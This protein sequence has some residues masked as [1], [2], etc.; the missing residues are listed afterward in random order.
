MYN[1][2]VEKF[3][4]VGSHKL[5]TVKMISVAIDNFGVARGEMSESQVGAWQGCCCKIHFNS[6]TKKKNLKS[7][8]LKLNKMLW[9]KI[10]L[11]LTECLENIEVLL[12]PLSI[13]RSQSVQL[14]LHMW[15]RTLGSTPGCRNFVHLH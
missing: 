6:D 11:V 13:R 5:G 2:E 3:P 9:Q 4:P 15:I 7:L 10:L 1:N 14:C 12:K 8:D